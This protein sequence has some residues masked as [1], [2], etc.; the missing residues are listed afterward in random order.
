[1]IGVR[2]PP[3]GSSSYIVL[4]A[5]ADG[6]F[7]AA[8]DNGSGLAAILRAARVL[9]DAPPDAGV[10]VAAMDAEE[11]GLVGAERFV[12]ALASPGGFAV[13]DGRRPLRI[14]DVKAVVNLD[15]SS[16][17][18]SDVQNAA[19]SLVRRD[20]PVFQ[21]RAMVSS[22]EPVV[23]AAGLARFAAHGVLGLPVP[24]SVFRPVA[25]GSLD[26]RLRSDVHWF[27]AHGIPF[28]WPVAGYPE[29]HT[30]GDTL[31]TVDAKDLENIALAAADLVRD[32]ASLPIGRVAAPFRPAA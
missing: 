27:A 31:A 7:Q 15:A 11:V 21:W 3:A 18:A 2:R 9:A 30:D 29:Y 10:I 6:W 19:A 14:D 5:H 23:T 22:E 16:A 24:A 26:G 4:L 20:V 25:A 17:R 28:F 8:A 1:V 32:Y 12:D 13:G